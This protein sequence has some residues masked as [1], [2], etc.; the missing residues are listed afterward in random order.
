MKELDFVQSICEE[1]TDI[2]ITDKKKNS[3]I[4]HI[5]AK[6]FKALNSRLTEKGFELIFKKS[7]SKGSY[8]VTYAFNK[9]K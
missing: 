9:N 7:V 3:I 1:F 6:Y 5:P 2:I 4:L 8:T